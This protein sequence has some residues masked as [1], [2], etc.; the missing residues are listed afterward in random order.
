MNL[1]LIQ[2]GEQDRKCRLIGCQFTENYMWKIT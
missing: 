2:L 1:G